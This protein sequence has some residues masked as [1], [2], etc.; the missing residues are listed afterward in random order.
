MPAKTTLVF[1]NVFVVAACALVYELSTAALASYVL[2][3][4]ITEF[5]IV[6]G[7]Y[8]AAMGVGAWLTR[9]VERR[10]TLAY[11]AI[12]IALAAIGGAS[13][14]LLF[15]LADASPRTG[16]VVYFAVFVIGLLVGF[17][18]PLLMRLLRGE[19]ALVERS[20]AWDNAGALFASLL[21]P[22]VL[23]PLLGLM[24]TSLVCGLANA[25][26]AASGT[27]VLR[28]ELSDRASNALRFASVVVAAGLIFGLVRAP[29]WALAWAQ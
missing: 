7:L 11:L 28:S 10:V 29:G 27:W 25:A 18:L 13:S 8:L 16:P 4:A 15:R 19:D 22:I 9:V 5:S 20:L 23:V 26:V 14:P 1:A 17:E 2:G 6:L 12:E 3:D 24:R 21:F